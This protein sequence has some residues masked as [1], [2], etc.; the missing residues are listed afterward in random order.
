MPVR[1]SASWLTL[2]WWPISNRELAEVSGLTDFDKGAGH[3][4]P[5]GKSHRLCELV[6]EFQSHSVSSEDNG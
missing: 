2:P 4:I 6:V 1:P 3:G 5:V